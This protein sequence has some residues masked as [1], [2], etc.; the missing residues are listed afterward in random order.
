M[1]TQPTRIRNR[2]RKSGLERRW[3]V[4]LGPLN[5]GRYCIS[6]GDTWRAFGYTSLGLTQIEIWTGN[7]DVGDLGPQVVL[8]PTAGVSE[9]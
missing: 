3:Q 6:A 5:L 1:V 7:T 2:G 4:Q 9:A 8:K